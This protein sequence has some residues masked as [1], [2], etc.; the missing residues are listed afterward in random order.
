M[1]EDC[2]IH[3][4]GK[5]ESQREL[6]FLFSISTLDKIKLFIILKFKCFMRRL[7]R[8]S[9]QKTSLILFPIGT[10]ELPESRM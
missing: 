2:S 4:D 7:N 3:I 1:S 6:A 8:S 5:Q 10:P 9:P